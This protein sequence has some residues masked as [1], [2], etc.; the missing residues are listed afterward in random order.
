MSASNTITREVPITLDGLFG[1]VLLRRTISAPGIPDRDYAVMEL[2]RRSY[3]EDGVFVPGADIAV[4]S[5]PDLLKVRNALLDA[6]PLS[7]FPA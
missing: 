4:W 2:A 3:V 6:L 1:R 5:V 7:E